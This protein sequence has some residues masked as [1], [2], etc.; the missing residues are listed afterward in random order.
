MSVWGKLSGGGIGLTIGGPIG[1]LIGAFA[2][3]YLIDRDGALFGAPPRDLILTTGLIALLAKMARADGVV[4]RSEVDAFEAVV[5]VPPGEHENVQRLFRLAQET[6][7]G[8]EVYARQ[9]AHAFA[10]EP[11]LLDDIIEGLFLIARADGAI[12]EAELV[13]IGA[14]A[15]I[16]G[17]DQA[18]FDAIVERHVHRRDDPYLELGADR[19][20]SD[21]ALKAH[22]RDLVLRHHPDREIA[23]GLPPEAIKIA[24]DR[25]ATINAAWD[26]IAK[27]RRL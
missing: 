4:L 25:L 23:R 21:G 17:R 9:L 1:A 3:H 12:H 15:A 16:F 13:Y 24:T 22:H 7:A 10:D 19:S 11:A 5:V 6:T 14:V 27:E 26:R 2:G 18:W 8:Y 20:W